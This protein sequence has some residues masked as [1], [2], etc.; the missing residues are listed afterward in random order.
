MKR[1]IFLLGCISAFNAYAQDVIVCRDG[2]EIESK[3]LK[4][5]QTEVEYK[6]WTNQDGPSYTLDKSKVFM[7]KYQNGEKDVF[8]EEPV[9][10]TTTTASQTGAQGESAPNEP[11]MAVA[12][13]DNE[14][15]IAEY[16]NAKFDYILR[17]PDKK[18]EKKAELFMGALGVSAFSILSTDDIEISF[19]QIISDWEIFDIRG[20]SAGVTIRSSV[21]CHAQRRKYAIIIRNKTSRTI[22]VD[23]ASCFAVSSSG[24]TKTYFDSQEYVVT[25]GK[26]SSSGASVNLGSVANAL[27]V[28]GVVGTLANGVSVGGDKGTFNAVTTMHKDNSILTIPPHA[29]VALSQDAVKAHPTEKYASILTGSYEYYNIF[30]E[31]LKVDEIRNYSEEDTPKS[32]KYMITYSYD[33]EF[34]QSFM[35][36]FGTY[37]KSI[38]GA[39]GKISVNLGFGSTSSLKVKSYI[40]PVSSKAIVVM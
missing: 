18:K 35:V 38:F 37:L 23:K 1:V 4:I 33:K 28:G 40:E 20:Y 12:A 6:K 11:V 31:S 16:N 32:F 26:N 25:E 15:L 13:A 39:T 9:Q 19:K 29:S 17:Y 34:T 22:Y 21:F 24:T 2:E 8:K 36:T 7:I 3:V 27:G 5:S 14:E 10:Q 30:D